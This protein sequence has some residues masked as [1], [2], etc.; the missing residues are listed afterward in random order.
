ME[1]RI[2][3]YLNGDLVVTTPSPPAPSPGKHGG[4]H[5]GDRMDAQVEIHVRQDVALHFDARRVFEHFEAVGGEP[6]HGPFGDV[7]DFLP[8][9]ARVGG[10][11]GDAFDAVDELAH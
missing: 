6:E 8:G 10:G 1:E 11:K 9:A 2:E 4:R 5:G 3:V 7:E